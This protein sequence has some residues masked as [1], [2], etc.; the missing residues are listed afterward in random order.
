MGGRE[1][2]EGASESNQNILHTFMSCQRTHSIK[3]TEMIRQYWQGFKD[4]VWARYVILALK[5][6]R[7]DDCH[8]FRA[9]LDYIVSSG[10]A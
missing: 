6:F 3:V 1:M 4:G 8:E 10:P 2:T 7:K 9:N 5:R